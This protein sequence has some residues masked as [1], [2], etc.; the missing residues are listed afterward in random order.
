MGFFL[1]EPVQTVAQHDSSV[2]LLCEFAYG[3]RLD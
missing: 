3:A 2:S 1:Y